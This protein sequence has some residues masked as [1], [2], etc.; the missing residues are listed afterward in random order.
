MLYLDSRSCS[1]FGELVI[2]SEA[3]RVYWKAMTDSEDPMHT[4]KHA[5]DVGGSIT[6]TNW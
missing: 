6:T 1:N 4:H 3:M 2:F 5:N